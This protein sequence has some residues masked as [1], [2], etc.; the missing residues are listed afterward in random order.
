ML[1]SG[2]QN[3]ASVTLSASESTV[4]FSPA[5]QATKFAVCYF[6]MIVNGPPGY[7]YKLQEVE[8]VGVGVVQQI[9]IG[10]STI[11]EAGV[12]AGNGEIN[13][14]VQNEVSSIVS[15]C[16]PDPTELNFMF[17]TSASIDAI[18]LKFSWSTC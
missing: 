13:N 2:T 14:F 7:Q 18:K 5:F 17:S 9:G 1:C 4:N 15:P 6:S 11:S 3:A 8:L 10:V 16:F 12:F